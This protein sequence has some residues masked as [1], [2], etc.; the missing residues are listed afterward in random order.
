MR[1]ESAWRERSAMTFAEFWPVY[2]RAH[3]RSGTRLVHLAGT[4]GGWMLVGAAIAERRW[5]WVLAA[6]L[7]AYGL[8]WLAHFFVAHHMPP[9]L[10]QPLFFWRADQRIVFLMLT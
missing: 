5:W 7:L 3:S 9:T 10:Q 1:R 6:L 2:V 8:A 4:L